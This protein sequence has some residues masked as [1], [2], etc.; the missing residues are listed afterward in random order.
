MSQLFYYHTDTSTSNDIIWNGAMEAPNFQSKLP[1]L[2]VPATAWDLGQSCI[3]IYWSTKI[4]NE[5]WRMAWMYLY[6]ESSYLVCGLR[7]VLE[8]IGVINLFIFIYKAAF[9]SE[10]WNKGIYSIVQR[11][12]WFRIEFSIQQ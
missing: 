3:L 12:I 4:Y 1:P 11:A 2:F 7:N 9:I 5:F 6:R 8:C 10:I